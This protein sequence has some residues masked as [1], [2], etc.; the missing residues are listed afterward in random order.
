MVINFIPGT[1]TQTWLQLS[2]QKI[3]SHLWLAINK[4]NNCL[5][6]HHKLIFYS[7]CHVQRVL[8][9]TTKVEQGTI[10]VGNKQLLMITGDLIAR[11]VTERAISCHHRWYLCLLHWII[12]SSIHLSFPRFVNSH[13]DLHR[14]LISINGVLIAKAVTQISL[15][16]HH[17]W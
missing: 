1:E 16:C 17:Q 4:Q 14:T 2:L 12:Q 10:R 9:V 7:T 13:P 6:H 5:T 15:S 8:V 11:K 3:D